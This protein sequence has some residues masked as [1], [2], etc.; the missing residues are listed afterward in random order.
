MIFCM[1]QVKDAFKRLSLLHH[2]D[3]VP[4]H[5]RKDAEA[6]FLKISTAY[7]QAI[8]QYGKSQSV[9]TMNC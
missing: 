6:R 3:R 4:E 9:C 2:P 8:R 1:L 7:S 5:K